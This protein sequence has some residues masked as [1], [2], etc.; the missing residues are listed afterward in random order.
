MFTGQMTYS[1]NE[2]VINITKR[3]KGLDELRGVAILLVLGAHQPINK[4]LTL[5]GWTGVTLFFV[6][7]GFLVSGL[8]FKEY[9]QN[10]TITPARFLA[11]RAVRIYPPFYV[12]LFTTVLISYFTDLKMTEP[13][14]RG[15]AALPLSNF[16]SEIFFLQNYHPGLWGQCWSLAVEEHF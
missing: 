4:I 3:I 5:S 7:S 15:G 16:L 14:W 6:L 9:Q 12:M 13:K 10:G 8:L 11:R 1:T 2:N